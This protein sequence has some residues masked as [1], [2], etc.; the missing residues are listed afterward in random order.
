MCTALLS[1]CILVVIMISITVILPSFQVKQRD[2]STTHYAVLG[3]R[4][5]D[6]PMILPPERAV[7]YTTIRPNIGSR[8][9]MS[10]GVQ[11]HIHN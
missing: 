4:R 2:G 10:D 9:N 1:T 8:P 6:A 5:S 3:Q 7:Q 11:V